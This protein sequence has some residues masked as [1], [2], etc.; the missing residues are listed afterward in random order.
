MFEQFSLVGDTEPACFATGKK[1]VLSKVRPL[2]KLAYS[3]LLLSKIC[4]VDEVVTASDV[5]TLVLVFVGWLA[6][7]GLVLAAAHLLLREV[8]HG[9]P[10][11]S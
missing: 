3:C 4:A 6:F 5:D 1:I 2:F 7:G 8:E 9:C 11:C 10:E